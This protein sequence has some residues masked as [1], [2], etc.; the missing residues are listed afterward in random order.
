MTFC[1]FFFVNESNRYA[2]ICYLLR[3]LSFNL[4]VFKS[5]FAGAKESKQSREK[6]FFRFDNDYQ[7]SAMPPS[8]SSFSFENG[9]LT[10]YLHH[11]RHHLEI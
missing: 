2:Y 8:S 4:S 11:H 10:N 1:M 6:R 5:L 7:P 9:M 3:K